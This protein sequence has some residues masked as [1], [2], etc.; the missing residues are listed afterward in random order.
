VTFSGQT[1]LKILG[2]LESLKRI[3]CIIMSEGVL[4]FTREFI[5]LTR[6]EE[7]QVLG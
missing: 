1:H 6:N 3:S 2:E 5:D 7:S 4:T